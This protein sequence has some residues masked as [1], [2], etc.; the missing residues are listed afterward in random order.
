MFF[1]AGFVVFTRIWRRR[2]KVTEVLITYGFG[3]VLLLLLGNEKPCLLKR[4]YKTYSDAGQK[5]P[6][7]GIS[8]PHVSAKVAAKE[9]QEEESQ[10]ML[11]KT[12]LAPQN[13]AHL[14][15]HNTSRNTQ[16]RNT[17]SRFRG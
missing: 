6:L 13:N 12:A 11:G 7:A 8:L 4:L 9:E 14:R 2:G 16:T 17:S 5:R 1:E 15:T 10:D 3:G